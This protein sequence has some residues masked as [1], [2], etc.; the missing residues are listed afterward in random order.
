[1]TEINEYKAGWRVIF[2]VLLLVAL[3]GPWYFDRVSVPSPYACSSGV[4]LDEVFCGLPG[5]GLRIVPYAFGGLFNM[6]REVFAPSRDV[7]TALHMVL[8]GSLPLLILLPFPSILFVM[9]RSENRRGQ[10]LHLLILGVAAVSTGLFLMLPAFS[11]LH[12]ALWGPWFYLCL[13][14]SLLLFE[15]LAF[16]ESGHPDPQA[17]AGVP[18]VPPGSVTDRPELL[19]SDHRGNGYP[20]YE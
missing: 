14:L 13:A 6:I 3:S 19:E 9:W 18:T 7:V 8:V 20:T 10:F 17:A 12:W 2:L 16:W 11:R 4:R 5:S 1:M 15:S